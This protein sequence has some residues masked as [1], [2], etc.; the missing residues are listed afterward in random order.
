MTDCTLPLTRFCAENILLMRQLKPFRSYD[1]ASQKRLLESA[2]TKLGGKNKQY[3]VNEAAKQPINANTRYLGLKNMR[4]VDPFKN[5]EDDAFETYRTEMRLILLQDPAFVKDHYHELQAVIQEG[6]KGL[7]EEQRL[8]FYERAVLATKDGYT[9]KV[10]KKSATVVGARIFG[11]VIKYFDQ[12]YLRHNT[13]YGCGLTR[14]TEWTSH[15][16]KVLTNPIDSAAFEQF[17]NIVH[18][19]E[20]SLVGKAIWR[21]W[22]DLNHEERESYYAKAFQTAASVDADTLFVMEKRTIARNNDYNSMMA[23]TAEQKELQQAWNDISEEV[24]KIYIDRALNYYLERD[25]NPKTRLVGIYDYHKELYLARVTTIDDMNAELMPRLP[26]SFVDSDNEKN[27]FL[28][29]MEKTRPELLKQ[30]EMLQKR[31]WEVNLVLWKQWNTLSEGEQQPYYDTVRRYLQIQSKLNGWKLEAWNVY[32]KG[33]NPYESRYQY[34]MLDTEAKKRYGKIALQNRK[35]LLKKFPD[36]H[37]YYFWIKPGYDIEHAP[38]ST[39]NSS[40]NADENKEKHVSQE[41]NNAYSPKFGFFMY[42]DSCDMNAFDEYRNEVMEMASKYMSINVWWK[43]FANLT[44]KER[45]AYYDR[46]FKKL[47][48]KRAR[49]LFSEDNCTRIR[50]SENDQAYADEMPRLKEAWKTLSI[51]AQNY[52]IELAEQKL[53]EREKEMPEDSNFKMQTAYHRNIELDYFPRNGCL[54]TKYTQMMYD[55][56]KPE[57]K[58]FAVYLKK[59]F[60]ELYNQPEMANK[61]YFQLCL[62]LEQR[63]MN[64]SDEERQIYLDIVQVINTINGE[65]RNLPVTTRDVYYLK[66]KTLKH[67]QSANDEEKAVWQEEAKQNLKTLMEKFPALT[68][69]FH[70]MVYRETSTE[71][72]VTATSKATEEASKEA[73]SS[74][75]WEVVNDN[76]AQK[77]K[78]TAST[79]D[80]E[81]I[82]AVVPEA[83]EQ[84]DASSKSLSDEPTVGGYTSKDFVKTETSVPDVEC[85]K[86]ADT[87]TVKVAVSEKNSESAKLAASNKDLFVYNKLLELISSKSMSAELQ[88]NPVDTEAAK[89]AI[90]DDKSES[91][92]FSVLNK[93]LNH[94]KKLLEIVSTESTSAELQKPLLND[95]TV[96]ESESAATWKAVDNGKNTEEDAPSKPTDTEAVEPAVS[97]NAPES[98]ANS[99]QAKKTPTAFMFYKKAMRRL[100]ADQNF[101]KKDNDS[102]RQALISGWKKLSDEDK[103]VYFEKERLARLHLEKQ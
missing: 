64:L 88:E 32:S 37:D 27:A 52:Y 103:A 22:M 63:F 49:N 12:R 81:I 23:Y 39:S 26:L 41:Q 90:P 40:S 20:P 94:L 73:E 31:F 4:E 48:T 60:T 30:P 66:H 18:A 58:A 98:S 62:I 102:Q 93:K 101:G 82:T 24:R 68:E 6:W 89:V 85:S 2:W 91:A 65:I 69:H 9:E 71:S 46:A 29:Y 77:V 33:Y 15:D 95:T 5:G 59:H 7:S 96:E 54:V 100:N 61:R 87:E 53:R 72:N 28:V 35:T 3:Y 19:E 56:G 57:K 45:N 75:T 42:A 99:V 11:D 16:Y 43:Q 84:K 1:E 70:W 79:T 8:D 47:A 86:S 92:K 83:V 50:T 10:E 67:W 13:P 34:A 78:E 38:K 55:S 21:K 14:G 25:Q 80:A 17:A 44:D 36:L 51:P 74:S 97:E 76:N